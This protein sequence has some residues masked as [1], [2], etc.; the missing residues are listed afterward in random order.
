MNELVLINE[1]SDIKKSEALL[2]V[3]ISFKPLAIK[4]ITSL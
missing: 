3:D 4:L 1:D 2:K